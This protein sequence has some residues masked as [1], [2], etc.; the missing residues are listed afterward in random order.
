MV[1]EVEPVDVIGTEVLTGKGTDEVMTGLGEGT[2]FRKGFSWRFNR[3]YAGHP[4]PISP[5]PW[6]VLTRGRGGWWFP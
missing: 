5:S 6:F 2:K 4:P 3:K 1:G